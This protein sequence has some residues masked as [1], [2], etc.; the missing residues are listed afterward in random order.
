MRP[1]RRSFL[2][3]D[4]GQGLVEY[5]VI[6]VLLSLALVTA[7]N[8]MTGSASNTFDHAGTSSDTVRGH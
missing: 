5:A 2:L 7:L 3:D 4:S 6:L 1:P 8:F